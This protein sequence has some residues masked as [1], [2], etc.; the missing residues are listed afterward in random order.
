MLAVFIV[1][2]IDLLIVAIFNLQARFSTTIR[3]YALFALSVTLWGWGVGFFFWVS[4]PKL[5]DFF[6]RFVYFAGGLI[7]PAFYYFTLC[8]NE[9]EAISNRKKFLI[10]F[11]SFIFLLFYF[12]TDLI[13]GGFAETTEARGFVYGQIRL[14]FDI[15]LWI[16]FVLALRKL[17]KKYKGSSEKQIQTQIIFITLG[18]YTVLVVGGLTNLFLP[19]FYDFRFIWMGPVTT[20]IWV[21][22]V[23]YALLK[24]QLLNTKVIATELFVALIW[25]AAIIETFLSQ[26][27]SEFFRKFAVLVIGVGLFGYF[28]IRSVLQEVRAREEIERLAR[29]LAMANEELKKLDVAKSEFISL[30]GHQ[31]RAPLTAIKGYA[32]MVLEGSFGEMAKRA[33]EALGRV[34]ISADQL[35]RLTSDLLDLSRIEAGKFEYNFEKNDL[36]KIIDKAMNELAWS[37]KEKGMELKFLDENSQKLLAMADSDKMHEVVLNL[38]D[39]ALKYSKIGR[40]NI[41]LRVI[42]FPQKFRITVKDQGIGIPKEELQKLFTKFARTEESKKIRPDGMGLGLYFV[43]KIVEDHGGRVWAESDGVGKGSVFIVELPVT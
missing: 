31:L 13:I 1:S 5:T 21:A 8:F 36:S 12:F 42:N 35:V 33:R 14:I 19:L 30:A 40:I 22:L 25:L 16:F 29:D 26:S 4:D 41:S 32:S 6:A 11:P 24:H 39:N 7:A 17:L 18:T 9:K 37:A 43:K 38:I 27:R 20:L 2:S 10:F 23:T 15:H 28:L 34:I 3:A